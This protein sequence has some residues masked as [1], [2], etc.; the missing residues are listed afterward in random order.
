MHNLI[1]IQFPSSWVHLIVVLC[2]YHVLHID[3]SSGNSPLLNRT[4][5]SLLYHPS[6]C[7][8]ALC[9]LPPPNPRLSTSASFASSS[10]PQQTAIGVDGFVG[11]HA[12]VMR[13][14]GGMFWR[15]S[16]SFLHL[17]PHPLHHHLWHRVACSFHTFCMG[18]EL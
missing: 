5:R 11:G 16:S 8:Q 15:A 18:K 7:S 14:L 2:T 4:N 3:N 12:L 1:L 6:R 9:H 17:P 10:I 13:H